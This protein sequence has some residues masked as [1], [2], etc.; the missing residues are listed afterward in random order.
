MAGA[1]ALVLLLL[2]PAGLAAPAAAS[3]GAPA[4]PT[5]WAWGTSVNLSISLQQAGTINVS[6]IPGTNNSPGQTFG[7]V[8]ISATEAYANYASLT[9]SG[10][11]NGSVRLQ[12]Q[13]VDARQVAL[14]V[15]YNATLPLAGTYP[16]GSVPPTAAS[17]G[18]AQIQLGS[19]EWIVA[20]LNL[21]SGNGSVAL[22]N[23]HVQ[24]LRAFN[25]SLTATNLP[26]ETGG[27]NASVTWKYTTGAIAA[28]GIV[29][30]NLSAAFSP[31]L[32]LV[33]PG[34]AS[35]WVT[36]SN[37]TFS[38]AESTAVAYRV[39]LP[40]GFSA[41]WSSSASASVSGTVPVTADCASAPLALPGG[42]PALAVNCT[43]DANTSL[44]GNGLVV[45][46][47]SALNGSVA[48]SPTGAGAPP[49]A[50]QSIP[51]RPVYRGGGAGPQTVTATPSA[52]DR[53]TAAPMDPA[54]AAVAMQDLRSGVQPPSELTRPGI[55]SAPILV[56]IAGVATVGLFLLAR[57]RGY[58]G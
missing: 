9:S 6:S 49:A 22:A 31:A 2:V 11:P 51:A 3:G 25:V 45:V 4:G 15:A 48:G 56:L 41:S 53:V 1:T 12:E 26:N 55:G 52:G 14:Q 54:S 34:N 19:L 47:N 32:T 38:G 29:V 5:T 17:V 57:R 36:R 46:P 44:V 23:E 58:L 27:P 43:T 39:A 35:S 40:A 33:G 30:A 18:A 21:S 20:F 50:A 37:A 16:Q 10:G 7:A 42:S 8:A 28:A 24:L 13:A